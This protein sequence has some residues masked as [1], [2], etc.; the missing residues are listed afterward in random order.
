MHGRA[1]LDRLLERMIPQGRGEA[2][3]PATQRA[4]HAQAVDLLLLSPEFLEA[5]APLA[6]HAVHAALAQGADVEVLSGEAAAHLNQA[7]GGI[8]ARLRFAIDGSPRH[9]TLN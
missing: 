7:A 9:D 6:E 4:L 1:L 8:A 2:G 5:H 3:V